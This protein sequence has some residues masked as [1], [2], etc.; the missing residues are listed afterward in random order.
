[1][2]SLKGKVAL[3]TGAASGIGQAIARTFAEA[4]AHVFVADRDADGG[5]KTVADIVGTGAAADFLSLDVT[6]EAECE[7]ARAVVHDRFGR[8][9]ILVNNAGVGH[10]GTMLQTTGSDLD[11]LYGVNVRGMFNLTKRCLRGR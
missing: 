11:R 4:G 8:L 10:V 1:M 5:V 2:F 9:D 3:V 7:A 6:R